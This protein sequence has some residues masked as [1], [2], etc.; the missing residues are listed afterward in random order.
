MFT[1]SP[2]SLE[3]SSHANEGAIEGHHVGERI[4]CLL[5]LDDDFAFFFFFR[6]FS[7][8]DWPNHKIEKIEHYE[9]NLSHKTIKT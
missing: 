2:W 8:N 6:S 4:T 7:V 5:R 1:K 9:T 3:Y